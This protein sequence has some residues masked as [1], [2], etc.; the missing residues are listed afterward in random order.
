MGLFLD[1][2]SVEFNKYHCKLLI[3]YFDMKSKADFCYVDKH[4]KMERYY[5]SQ[6]AAEFVL[7]ELCKDPENIL[8]KLK[9]KKVPGAKAF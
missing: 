2:N 3:D 5:Y 8:T 6:K 9:T 4:D 7:R 1:G